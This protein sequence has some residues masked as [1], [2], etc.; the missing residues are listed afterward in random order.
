MVLLSSIICDYIPNDSSSSNTFNP[1]NIQPSDFSSQVNL[2]FDYNRRPCVNP[3]E[4]AQDCTLAQKDY[5][6]ELH[7]VMNLFLDLS[8]FC[9]CGKKLI[10]RVLRDCFWESRHAR[11]HNTVDKLGTY[12]MFTLKLGT[13]DIFFFRRRRRY[14]A[15]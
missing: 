3:I 6:K 2:G 15:G 5:H 13:A 7:K 4:A 12:E 10:H 9:F 1:Q 14:M 8:V 11:G